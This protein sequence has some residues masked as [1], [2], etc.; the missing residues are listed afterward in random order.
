MVNGNPY[1][2]R[3]RRPAEFRDPRLQGQMVSP[4]LRWPSKNDAFWAAALA[5]C[6]MVSTRHFHGRWGC[7]IHRKQLGVAVRRLRQIQGRSAQLRFGSKLGGELGQLA[8]A[9]PA[10]RVGY[11]IGFRKGLLERS[12]AESRLRQVEEKR[13]HALRIKTICI[14]PRARTCRRRGAL[15]WRARIARRR[16]SVITLSVFAAIHSG[17]SHQIC[18]WV[19]SRAWSGVGAGFG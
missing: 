12:S 19:D 11:D 14:A 10:R 17:R 3:N 4:I 18:T 1:L 13:L 6:P 15:R 16:R 5:V 9:G 2:V 8:R 7:K